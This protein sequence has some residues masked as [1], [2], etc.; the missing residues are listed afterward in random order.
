MRVSGGKRQNA[1]DGAIELARIAAGEVAAGGAEIRH[2][3]R[4]ANEHSIPNDVGDTGWRVA[5]RMQHAGLQAADFERLAIGPKVIELRAICR[6]FRAKVQQFAERN[7][8][9]INRAADSDLAA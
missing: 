3:N 7:L 1:L 9:L 8:H 6:E 4:I 2:E 5:R